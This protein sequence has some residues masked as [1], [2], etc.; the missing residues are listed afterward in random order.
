MQ[1]IIQMLLKLC[2]ATAIHNLSWG[3]TIADL[4]IKTHF[5]FLMTV[6]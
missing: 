3:Q 6:I 1:I 2:L 5:S 4:Y